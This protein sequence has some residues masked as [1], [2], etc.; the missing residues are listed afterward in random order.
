MDSLYLWSVL[1]CH[2]I[3]YDVSHS[4]AAV[5]IPVILYICA[6][7]MWG[8]GFNLLVIIVCS[9]CLV[10]FGKRHKKCCFTL[11]MAST[12]SEE[13]ANEETDAGFLG[14]LF[15]WQTETNR[16]LLFTA[17]RGGGSSEFWRKCWPLDA[18]VVHS[19]VRRQGHFYLL[20]F[21]PVTL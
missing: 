3:T 19:N 18:S 6:V 5:K 13:E 8:N 16:S 17:R 14:T 1:K 15:E 12:F 9:S 7:I 10:R 4:W 20:F 2:Q 11:V 21:P